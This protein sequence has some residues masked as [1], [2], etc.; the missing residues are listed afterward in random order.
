MKAM[1]L[2][3]SED[4]STL[5]FEKPQFGMEIKLEAVIS[6]IQFLPELW[7]K[8]FAKWTEILDKQTIT[9]FE[10]FVLELVVLYNWHLCYL[11]V[12]PECQEW[13]EAEAGVEA[14]EGTASGREQSG[15]YDDGQKDSRDPT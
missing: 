1:Q 12:F 6:N 8:I 9:T 2:F 4:F 14:S 10:F 3:T 11:S 13:V 5:K 15:H 7:R